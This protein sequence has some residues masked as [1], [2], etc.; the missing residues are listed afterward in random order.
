MKDED[1]ELAE[2]HIELA[3][4]IVIEQGKNADGKRKEA[5]E[6]AAFELEKAQA[7]IEE[8]KN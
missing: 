5:L 4:N 3:E 1:M 8:S 6:D 7:D 2:E